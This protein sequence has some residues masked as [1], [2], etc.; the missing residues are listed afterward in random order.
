MNKIYKVIWSKVKACYVVV[1]EL[2][3]RHSKCKSAKPAISLAA[4]V[5]AFM[6]TAGHGVVYATD[7]AP[8]DNV[9]KIGAIT[10]DSSKVDDSKFSRIVNIDGFIIDNSV[11]NYGSFSQ[12]MQNI[13]GRYNQ[14]GTNRSDTLLGLDGGNTALGCLTLAGIELERNEIKDADGNVIN[15]TY[16][17]ELAPT[18]GARFKKAD[19]HKD[20]GYATALGFATA[21]A[22]TNAIATGHYTVADGLNAF[23][24]GSASMA[25]NDNAFAFGRG[26]LAAGKNSFAFGEGWRRTPSEEPKL[27]A[28]GKNSVAM[29]DST[30]AFGTNSVAL[31]HSTKASGQDSVALN[32]WTEAKGFASLAAGNSSKAL[33]DNSTALSG[34]IVA[35]DAKNAAAIGK[36]ASAQLADSVALGSKSIADRAG[37]AYGYDPLTGAVFTNNAEVAAALGKTDEYN[38]LT[39]AVNANW[40]TYEEKKAAYKAAET[41]YY[42]NHDD[43]QE[44]T[45]KEAYQQAQ[46]AYYAS[47]DAYNVSN[48]QRRAD[49]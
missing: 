29:G 26:V 13:Y 2:A 48:D 7:L 27:I 41:A 1:S 35:A 45:L 12:Y 43:A 4:L 40:A 19:G 20:Y 16:A 6:L 14:V 32:G 22:K 15:V 47:I 30:K 11:Q 8:T 28:S 9:G 33:A 24:G 36:D 34:G 5:T 37:N 10:I 46:S 38:T 39:D 44:E 42:N 17:T 3:K 18:G 31:G 23:S 49:F 25:T 21:A